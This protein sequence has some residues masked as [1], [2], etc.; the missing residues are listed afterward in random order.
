MVN[1]KII[2]FAFFVS[3]SIFMIGQS[4]DSSLEEDKSKTNFFQLGMNVGPLIK[5]LLNKGDLGENLSQGTISFKNLKNNLAFRYGVSFSYQKQKN[6][7]NSNGTSSFSTTGWI[8]L[9]RQK[10][11]S[12]RWQYYVGGD[13]KYSY[14]SIDNN[15]FEDNTQFK[16][17]TLAPLVGVQY[18]ITP[19]LM[20]Q[21]EASL[22]IFYSE[23]NNIFNFQPFPIDP[24]F[25]TKSNSVGV[26][27]SL[28]NILNLVFEL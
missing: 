17:F 20:L 15:F 9:E 13:I 11:V 10:I 27:I 7:G 16:T 14:T 6:D 3:F 18:R 5:S 1:K 23:A 21:T 24:F 8:G 22:N 4:P 2:S 19:K 26:N 25:A 28:P 12:K